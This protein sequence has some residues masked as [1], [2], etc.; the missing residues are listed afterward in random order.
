[1]EGLALEDV[2]IFYGRLVHFTVFFNIFYGHLVQFVVIWYI[3]PV[4]VFCTK[5]NLATLVTTNQTKEID[6]SLLKPNFF[7]SRVTRLGEFF[8]IGRLFTL[9]GVF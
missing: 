7:S 9:A 3:F 2:G 1:L 4:S 6:V 5:K 8:P